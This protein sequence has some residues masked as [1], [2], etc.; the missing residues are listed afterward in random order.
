MKK[1][2]DWR[3]IPLL[4]IVMLTAG[5]LIL[6]FSNAVKPRD[7]FHAN[8]LGLPTRMELANLIEAWQTGGYGQAF[9]NSMIVGFSCIIII[10]ISAGFAAYALSKIA[11]KG[12]EL[13][14]GFL[15]FTLSI[16]MGLFLVPLFFIWKQ[17]NLMDSLL[18]IIL[19]YSAIFLPLTSFCSDLFLSRSQTN[20][21][22]V[23]KLTAAMNYK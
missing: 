14:M 11:F 16:P 5:P 22:I 9:L 1:Y 20:F 6:L 12:S 15:L 3:H 4:F 18:G 13:I 19:I 23:R 21:W 2:L 10:T 7:E 17:L 8:P